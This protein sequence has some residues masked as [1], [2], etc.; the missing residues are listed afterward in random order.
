[1]S[2]EDDTLSAMAV[3]P[4]SRAQ[5]RAVPDARKAAIYT[6]LSRDPDG[7]ETATKRQAEDCRKRAEAEGWAIVAEYRDADLSAFKRSVKRPGFEQMLNDVRA[8]LVDVV[9]VWRLDR[10]ARQPRDLERFVDVAEPR[11]VELVS[12][13]EPI[14]LGNGTGLLLTRILAGFAS[15]ESQV[16]SERIR[17]KM[18][19]LVKDGRWHGGGSRP[20]G[21]EPDRL[22]IRRAEAKLIREAAKRIVAGES[23]RSVVTDWNSRGIPT[24]T[25]GEWKSGVLRRI[26]VASRT[27]GYSEHPELGRVEAT[28]DAI[29]DADTHEQLRAILLDPSRDRR[30]TTPVRKYLL[31][32]FLFCAECGKKLVARP[33]DDKRRNYVCASGANFSGCGR[34]AGL[35]EPIEELAAEAV[36]VALN[37][38]RFTRALLAAQESEDERDLIDQLRGCEDRIERLE[39]DYYVEAS[40]SSRAT[41]AAAPNSTSAATSSAAGL[42]IG[43]ATRR[44]RELRSVTRKHSDEPGSETASSGVAL[45]SPP[46]SRRSSSGAE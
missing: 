20:F 42:G 23:L 22:T 12:Y 46:C 30:G 28:W 34:T 35:A 9:L 18:V 3:K 13:T 45:C 5:R 27:A 24:T 33:K 4:K 29:L 2:L 39:H 32:G 10:L 41:D 38:P 37:T 7:T 11:G 8:G 44:S 26:L 16:K 17:R 40:S 25:G 14:T 21:Y 6:R 43:A 31:T 1:M 19:E 15:H 36:F